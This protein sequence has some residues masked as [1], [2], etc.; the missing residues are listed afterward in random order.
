MTSNC[1]EQFLLAKNFVILDKM[2]E[3][4]HITQR[5]YRMLSN[6]LENG[7]GTVFFHYNEFKEILDFYKNHGERCF[8]CHSKDTMCTEMTLTVQNGVRVG[9]L[10]CPS[11][12]TKLVKDL[13]NVSGWKNPVFHH[14]KV[15]HVM[16]RGSDYN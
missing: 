15:V 14:C 10:M 5:L 4:G 9:A 6:L 16:R 11:C 8:S 7:Y 12:V 1:L 3:N 13:N 2:R